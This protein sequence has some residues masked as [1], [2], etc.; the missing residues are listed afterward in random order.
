MLCAAVNHQ[1]L[2]VNESQT[3]LCLSI[4]KACKAAE[5]DVTFEAYKSCSSTADS[6][7]RWDRLSILPSLSTRMLLT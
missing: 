2:Y 6:C 3:K 5:G 1:C 4:C 7:E